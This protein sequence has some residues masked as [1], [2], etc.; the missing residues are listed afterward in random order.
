MEHE[1]GGP[2]INILL[3]IGGKSSRMGTRK[4]LLKFPD[5]RVAF[6][7]ALETIHDAVPTASTIF[8]SVHNKAQLEGIE[9][10]LNDIVTLNRTAE[11]AR[12]DQHGLNQHAF[13]MLKPIFDGQGA[14]IGPA[15]G[16]LAAYSR[17]PEA[18]WLVLGCDYPLLPPSALQQLVR[19]YQSPAT[20]FINKSGFAEP[21]IAICM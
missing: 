14:D 12:H 18:K 4:E 21:L 11:D 10:R 6:E 3:L 13:P 7:H 5:G 15:A 1:G 8:I 16:L 9:A 19:E 20:C 17:H 2:A